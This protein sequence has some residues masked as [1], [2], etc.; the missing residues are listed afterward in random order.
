MR[1][2]AER[3]LQSSIRSTFSSGRCTMQPTTGSY[4][5]PRFISRDRLT[6]TLSAP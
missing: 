2:D 4:L 6:M 5:P 3:S 1:F